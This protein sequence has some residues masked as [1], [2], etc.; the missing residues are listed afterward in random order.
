MEAENCRERMLAVTS[1]TRITSGSSR[2]TERCS[3]QKLGSSLRGMPFSPSFFASRCTAMK[4]PV[5]YRMAGRMAHS[6]TWP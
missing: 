3:F 6:V 5:K 4:M 2:Y 1:H